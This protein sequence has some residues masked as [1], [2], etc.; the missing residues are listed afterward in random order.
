MYR[1]NVTAVRSERCPL[2]MNRREK[3]YGDEEGEYRRFS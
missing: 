1:E 3:D 2:R